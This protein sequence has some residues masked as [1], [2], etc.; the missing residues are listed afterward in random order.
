MNIVFSATRQWNPGDEFILMGSINL[1]KKHISDFNPI[2][3]NRNPQIR[4]SRHFDF[5]KII[6]GLLG[7]NVLE[8]FLDNSVKEYN[9]MDYADLV[10]FAGSPEWRGK[11]TIKLYRSIVEYQIPTLFLGIG[12][13]AGGQF[14]FT[15]QY[16]SKDEQYVFNHAKLIT[17][18][19]RYAS[20]NL[21]PLSVHQLPCPALFSSTQEKTVKQV[22]KVGLIY[23]TNKAAN[24]NKISTDTYHY[25]MKMYQQLLEKFG[26]YYEFEFIAH[27]IDE[28]SEFK[29]DFSDSR[30][31][32]SY[33]SKDYL[34][35]YNQFDLVIGCRVHGIGIS[36][37]M[38]IPGMMIAHDNRSDT[39]QGFCAELIKVGDDFSKI[40]GTFNK[41]VAGIESYSL[42][43]QKHKMETAKKYFSLLQN[44]LL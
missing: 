41:M 6:D 27:Y 43:L 30:L 35:I 19:D 23:S 37:S 34:D 44:C 9:P 28:L 15:D 1:I 7:K 25:M 33:D 2:L 16:F 42:S 32:Y 18:R 20:E 4:R 11:R 14:S 26:E 24:G 40:I 38:G 5:I 17:A 29:N 12:L 36:A 13:G 39:V 21:Q 22:K 3:Y 31:H 10:V 8:K